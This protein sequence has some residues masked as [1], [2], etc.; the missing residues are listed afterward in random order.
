VV[1]ADQKIVPSLTRTVQ[2]TGLAHVTLVT[3]SAPVGAVTACHVWP[4]SP[5]VST[6][7]V[8]GLEP[9]DPTA[10]QRVVRGHETPVSWGAS[11]SSNGWAA[12]VR[13]PSDVAAMTVTG[14]TGADDGVGALGP[15]TPTAQQWSASAQETAPS[16]PVPGGAG[17]PRDTGVPF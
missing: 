7:P 10:M 11:V 8:G 2:S 3:A 14:E 13:P 9:V 16:S 15:A 4:P 1:T 5:V 6:V 12:Q 17:W